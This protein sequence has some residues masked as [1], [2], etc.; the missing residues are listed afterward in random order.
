MLNSFIPMIMGTGGNAGS[1]SSVTIIRGLSLGEIKLRDTLRIVWKELRIALLCGLTIAPVTFLK[2]MYLD[3]LYAEADGLIIAIVISITIVVT[4]CSAKLVGALLPVLAKIVH[5]D[6]AVMASPFITVIVDA[7][8]L[9][10]Y[11][12]FASM[13]VPALTL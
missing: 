1:Q 9:V 10:V 5:L 7:L 3:G 11:F 4:I 13:L 8:S 12:T 6:P 2:A